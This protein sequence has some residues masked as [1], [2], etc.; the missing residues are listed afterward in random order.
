[1]SGTCK[2]FA[3]LP[4]SFEFNAEFLSLSSNLRNGATIPLRHSQ[5]FYPK[6]NSRNTIRAICICLAVLFCSLAAHAQ[7]GRDSNVQNLPLQFNTNTGTHQSLRLKKRRLTRYSGWRDRNGTYSCTRPV[8]STLSLLVALKHLA[9]V[10]R[11]KS[12]RPANLSIAV[13]QSSEPSKI[14][15]PT[16]SFWN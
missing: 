1:M 6:M 9:E 11:R 16:L 8:S 12:T 7:S 4:P 2:G 13:K 14:A 10:H 15:R 5:F 3:S